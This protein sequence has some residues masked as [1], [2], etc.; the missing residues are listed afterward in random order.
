[1]I[2][3]Q[4]GI[5]QVILKADIA[6]QGIMLFTEKREYAIG[7]TDLDA[8]PGLSDWTPSSDGLVTLPSP[9][10]SISCA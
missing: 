10:S 6:C 1:V 7:I 4:Q 5:Q 9:G 2:T 8:A 3:T